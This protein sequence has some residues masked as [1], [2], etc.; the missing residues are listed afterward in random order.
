LNFLGKGE[1]RRIKTKIKKALNMGGV[2]D[3]SGKIYFS[4]LTLEIT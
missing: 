1:I 3:A 2:T 4:L